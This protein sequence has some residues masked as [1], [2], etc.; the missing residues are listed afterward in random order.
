MSRATGTCLGVVGNSRQV[1]GVIGQVGLVRDER[2]DNCR[3]RAYGVGRFHKDLE[4]RGQLWQ[5]TT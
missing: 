2:G 5:P 3:L 1:N 4:F